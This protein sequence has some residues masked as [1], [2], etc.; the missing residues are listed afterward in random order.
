MLL[1]A[2]LAGCSMP[3]FLSQAPQAR[4]NTVDVA[5]L[6]QLVPGTSTRSDVTTLLGSPT[7]KATFDDNTWLYIGEVTRPVIGGTQS[8]LDQQVV[9]LTFDDKGVLRSIT[10]KTADDALP[11]GMASG[12][13]PS[14]GSEA[15]VM[16]QLLGNVGR[17]NPIGAAGPSAGSS[18]VSSGGSSGGY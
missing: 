9:A 1:L 16:Q 3:A 2:T 15:T 6:K 17:F 5:D 12:A 14:P 18:G 10:R 13:T 4:G 11:V 8:V 7:A